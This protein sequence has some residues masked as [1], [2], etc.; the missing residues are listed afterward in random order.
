MT[1]APKRRWFQFSLRTVLLCF[2]PYVPIV[3]CIL[4]LVA[5]PM[6]EPNPFALG[7]NLIFE[8][9]ERNLRLLGAAVFTIAWF[10]AWFGAMPSWRLL[11][12]AWRRIRARSIP[13]PNP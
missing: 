5:T 4:S 2:V 13:A 1:S 3:S 8:Q 9:L 6:P 12:R 10:F 11:K 7:L